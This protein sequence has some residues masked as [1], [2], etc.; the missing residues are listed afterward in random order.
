MTTQVADT[1]FFDGRRWMIEKYG[2][3]DKIVPRSQELGFKTV[4]R[5]TANWSG[6]VDHFIVHNRFLYLHK[7][8]VKLHP[9][10]EDFVPEGAGKEVVLRYEPATICDS[11]GCRQSWWTHEF[12][13]FV[14]GGGNLKL[15]YTGELSL[16]YPHIDLWEIPATD[17]EDDEDYS[18]SAILSF[19]DGELIDHYIDD[20]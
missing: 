7:I 4:S 5:S 10:Y 6:R 13:Y 8:E 20:I 1:C 3:L 11:Q 2:G 18:K 12:L 9:D 17:K 16:L 19:K 14:F 15:K